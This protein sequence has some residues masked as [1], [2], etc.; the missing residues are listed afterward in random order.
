MMDDNEVE[1]ERSVEESMEKQILKLQSIIYDLEVFEEIYTDKWVDFRNM[2]NQLENFK[3][4]LE[5]DIVK[6]IKASLEK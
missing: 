1:D 4:S 3:K 2:I 5:K 6:D